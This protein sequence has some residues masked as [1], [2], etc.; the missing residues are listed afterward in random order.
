MLWEDR[1]I[2]SI[3]RRYAKPPKPFS[4]KEIALLKTFADQAVIAIQNARLF[5]ETQEALEQQKAAAEILSVIS[6]SVSDTKPVF[7]KILSSCKHLFGSDE[8]DVLLVDDQGQLQIAAYS[9]K[10]HDAVA[11]TFPAPV[12]KTPAGRAI[13]ERRVVHYPDVINGTDVPN[14]VRRVSKIAG[15][16]SM[17]FAPMLWEDRGIGAIGIARASGAYTA[18]ELALVQTFADQ[19]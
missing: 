12:E 2:S 5:N 10:V 7:D 4:D 16:Q 9:G 14:V 11:A 15:Y 8:M 17:A 1:G 13:H 6:S 18:K 3:A 19:A